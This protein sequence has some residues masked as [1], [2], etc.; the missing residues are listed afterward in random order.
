MWTIATTVHNRTQLFGNALASWIKHKP[1]DAALVVVDWDGHT[2]P[3]TTTLHLQ[4]MFSLGQ[5]RNVALQACT[6]E[7]FV[8]LDA[9]MLI[10]TSFFP[11]LLT[12][13]KQG[14][15]CFPMYDI[16]EE[17]GTCRFVG[18]GWGNCAFPTKAV[19]GRWEENTRWGGEDTA[20]K[21]SLKIPIWREHIKGF[22]HQWHTRKGTAW[23]ESEKLQAYV[24]EMK[25][26][27]VLQST[28]QKDGQY[29]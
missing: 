20:F 25:E 2:Y 19:Q 28:R 27:W 14:K 5:S 13:L 4:G 29:N 8:W 16:Q 12:P 7:L 6:T 18:K 24:K 10:P 26:P 11:T 17:N 3:R 1:A 22:V 21:N 9:D 23:Y 15:A